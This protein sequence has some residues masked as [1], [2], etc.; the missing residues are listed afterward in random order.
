[1]FMQFPVEDITH[2]FSRNQSEVAKETLREQGKLSPESESTPEEEKPLQPTTLEGAIRL[3]STPC[4]KVISPEFS[5][6]IAKWL[7]TCLMAQG[8]KKE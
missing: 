6:Q 8:G 1:M 4:E 5:M 7:K 2:N 3:F